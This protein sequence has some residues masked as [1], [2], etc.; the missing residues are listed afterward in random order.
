[1]LSSCFASIEVSD[2][3][4]AVYNTLIGDP[5]YV[6]ADEYSKLINANPFSKVENDI[7]IRK[8]IYVLN[9]QVDLCR[10]NYIRKKVR[11]KAQ[12]INFVMLMMSDFCNLS[13]D[14]CIEKQYNNAN[15]GTC[16]TRDV[17]DA[18]FDMIFSGKIKL[19]SDVEFVLYGGEPLLNVGVIRYFL[20]LREKYLPKSRCSIVTNAVLLNKDI[21][22]MFYKYNVVIGISIDGPKVITDFHRKYKKRE[23][24]KSVFEDVQKVIPILQGSNVEWGMS[25]TIT[26]ELIDHKKTLYEWLVTAKPVAVSFNMLKMSFDSSEKQT[27]I[28]YY[29]NAAEFMIEAHL[30]LQELNIKEIYITRKIRYFLAHHP[31][32]SDCAAAS[33]NQITVNTNG[34]LYSCQCYM[35][36]F[37]CFGNV[38]N[39]ETFA[40]P[41]ECKKIF[42]HLP[43]FK[44]SCIK[45]KALP[46]CGGG[47]LVQGRE[48]FCNSQCLDQAYCEY[49][50]SIAKWIYKYLYDSI[51]KDMP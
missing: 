33:L 26:D 43:I 30:K 49:A 10:I 21:I 17:V 28:E 48:F 2:G 6:S 16:M 22:E 3:L 36:D 18:F 37:N 5:V 25:I 11:R 42:E 38:F 31:V 15:K 44:E 4:Y 9:K 23:N 32:I 12:T 35:K 27:A 47:C 29:Q 34:D 1:M 50:Q 39:H 46:V 8:G 20:N 40:I 13:C 45:C 7:L 51:D 41:S 24:E 14:Y 19:S